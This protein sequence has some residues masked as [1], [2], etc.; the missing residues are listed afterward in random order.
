MHPQ[1]VYIST[2]VLPY[3]SSVSTII[4]YL[5]HG[6]IWQYALR[7]HRGS[8]YSRHSKTSHDIGKLLSG[9]VG[10]LE[11]CSM[12]ALVSEVEVNS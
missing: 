4:P 10:N 5:I 12:L 3:S 11:D 8:Y 9:L 1:P 2:T 6:N 7:G